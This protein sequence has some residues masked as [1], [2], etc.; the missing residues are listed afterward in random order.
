MPLS[1]F[2]FCYRLTG[3]APTIRRYP[4]LHAPGIVGG[5]LVTL[6]S[7]SA[8]LAATGDGA[9]LGAALA[10]EAGAEYIEVIADDDA[11]YAVEDPHRR[12]AGDRLDVTGSS[13]VQG[14]VEGPSEDFE[15]VVDSTAAEET[16]LRITVGR[17][18][19]FSIAV[20]SRTVDAA[21]LSPS[22][23]RQLVVAAA[24][25]DAAACA[26]LVDAFMPAISGIARRYRTAYSVQRAELLQEGVVGLLRALKRFDPTAT[27]P[28]W[29]YASWWVRQAM[30]Q[31]VAEVTRPTV[32]SD[33]GQRALA[34][35]R[36]AR[37][38]HLQAHGREPSIDELV[39]V[40]GLNRNQVESILVV[41]R[42][43]R[44]LSEPLEVDGTAG[45]LGEQIADPVAEDAYES[46]IDQVV[47]DQ[48]RV[49]TDVLDARERAILHDHYGLGGPAQSLRQ[50]AGA[51][52]M[53][54]ERVRQ[55][56]E[57][58]LDKLR[59]AAF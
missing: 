21:F 39:A 20:P 5:D 16:L 50:I 59:S 53:S 56:E 19:G 43:P 4:R 7:G 49:L 25:G 35:V 24:A 32:L 52:G 10:F 23:E 48:I 45:T 11:V 14:C 51:L 40:S 1:G 44:G 58:A 47:T 57:R 8:A 54:A 28:F 31:L 6:A 9:L 15:V 27:T 34:R 33:R 55:I 41:E 2:A 13:G 3:A 22:R 29:A 17:H 37:R 36:E 46:V 26:E 42:A 12:S 38:T 18:E 30:Q